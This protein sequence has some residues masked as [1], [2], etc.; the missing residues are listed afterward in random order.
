MA[1]LKIEARETY[2]EHG[3]QLSNKLVATNVEIK[4]FDDDKLMAETTLEALVTKFL[5]MSSEYAQL[6]AAIGAVKADKDS[7]IIIAKE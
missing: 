3:A 2:L 4:I 1:K 7:K 6:M 5:I